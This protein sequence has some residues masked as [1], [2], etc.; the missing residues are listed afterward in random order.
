MTL[1]RNHCR[2]W[3]KIIQMHKQ[4]QTCKLAVDAIIQV[5][6]FF[7]CH[8]NFP[9]LS[10]ESSPSANLKSY[11]RLAEILLESI[12]VSLLLVQNGFVMMS[13]ISCTITSGLLEA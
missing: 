8:Q 9:E 3:T 10:L 12:A 13:A 6:C 11:R 2:G 7:D 4:S 1:Q 5:C